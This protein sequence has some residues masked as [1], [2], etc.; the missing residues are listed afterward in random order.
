MFVVSIHGDLQAIRSHLGDLEQNLVPAATVSALNRT[1]KHILSESAKELAE[2]LSVPQ[3]HVRGRLAFGKA[4]RKRQSI[5]R[6]LKH[7]PINPGAISRT[8]A[9]RRAK[10][11]NGFVVDPGVGA[12]MAARQGR[13]KDGKSKVSWV[14]VR[15]SGS[16]HRF[17]AQRGRKIFPVAMVFKRKGKKRLPLWGPSDYKA[18]DP[19]PGLKMFPAGARILERRAKDSRAF[20]AKQFDHELKYRLMR[21]TEASSRAAY[22]DS[23]LNSGI[24]LEMGIDV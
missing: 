10:L 20:F 3:K 1:A 6:Y 13:T 23:L 18:P 9:K 14:A 2:Q 4:S 7:K 22:A 5:A 24:D 17:T 21:R 11:I 15:K 8:A 12:T 16:V 19:S